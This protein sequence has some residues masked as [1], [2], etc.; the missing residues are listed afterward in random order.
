[1]EPGDNFRPEDQ[2]WSARWKPNTWTAPPDRGEHQPC[3]A[4]FPPTYSPNDNP[5]E[6]LWKQMHDHVT[7]N[8]RH[9][10]IETL[11]KD[12]EG[13]LHHVQ[14]FPGTQVSTLRTA[15]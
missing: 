6:R 15:A 10:T 5:I 4:A 11:I 9:S 7:R 14:P 1:M 8:H 12:V 13:F 2:R 3:G